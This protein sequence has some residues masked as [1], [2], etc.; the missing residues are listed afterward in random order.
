M[1]PKRIEIFKKASSCFKKVLNSLKLSLICNAFLKKSLAFS[2][3]YLVA[4]AALPQWPV[5]PCFYPF[6]F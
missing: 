4:I 2:K 6:G 5:R 1:S 3:K